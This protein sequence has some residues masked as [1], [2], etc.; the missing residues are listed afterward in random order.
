MPHVRRIVELKGPASTGRS[1]KKTSAGP[2]PKME[3]FKG[4]HCRVR[5]FWNIENPCKVGPGSLRQEGS[6]FCAAYCP[7]GGRA[8]YKPG[9]TGLQYT[10]QGP[11]THNEIYRGQGNAVSAFVQL[12]TRAYSQGNDPW[13]KLVVATETL[14]SPHS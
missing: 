9:T 13:R 11:F 5:G 12:L 8:N 1:E 6:H 4:F 2:G 14:A 7:F 10:D 3:A